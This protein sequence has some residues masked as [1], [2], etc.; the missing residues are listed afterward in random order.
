MLY[1]EVH[2]EGMLLYLAHKDPGN[3]VSIA[4][5][6]K[7][8]LQSAVLNTPQTLALGRLAGINNQQM[9]RL[10]SFLRTVGKAELKYQRSKIT[11]I[12]HAVGIH[13][14]TPEP[15]FNKFTLEWA[16]TSGKDVK[17]KLPEQC[18]YW[19]SNL[20]LEVAAEIDMLVSDT[21]LLYTSDAADE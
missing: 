12:D 8:V 14:A 10:R 1:S 5:Q 21:C 13:P 15:I 6:K 18:S 2:Q 20:L 16:T 11:R 17:K 3:Y 9:E 19:N 7:L 4:N